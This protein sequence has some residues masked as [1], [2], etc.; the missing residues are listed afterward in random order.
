MC[1]CVC[2]CVFVFVCANTQV[3]YASDLWSL[4]AT[5][6]HLVSGVLPFDASRRA[7]ERRRGREQE[8]RRERRRVGERG[9]ERGS[10]RERD[11]ERER[12]RERER[13]NGESKMER[14][15]VIEGD[16]KI[17]TGREGGREGGGVSE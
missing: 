14:G 4:S 5:L 16:M 1:V 8:R 3:S 10:E 6:F 7:N 9:R 11:R 15:R 2:V 17:G 12:E 13:I